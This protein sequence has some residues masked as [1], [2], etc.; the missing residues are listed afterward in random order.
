MA[1]YKIEDFH[2]NYRNELFGG[3]DIKGLNIYTEQ[4]EKVGTVSTALVDD[5]GRFRYLVMDTGFWIF[6]KKVLL[7]VGRFRSD[8]RSQRI[9]LK[10]LS[11]QQAEQL[12]EYDEHMTVDYDYEERVRGVYRTAPL[13]NGV[14]LERMPTETRTAAVSAP[15]PSE[16]VRNNIPPAQPVVNPPVSNTTTS[17]PGFDR[18]DRDA[19][20]DRTPYNRNTYRYEQEPSLYSMNEQDHQ[21]FR[22]YEEQLVANKDRRKVGE[23]SVGKRIETETTQVAVPV[24]QERVVIQHNP[25]ANRGVAVTPGATDF[26]SGEVMRVDL[27]EETVDITK[28][29][30]VRDEVVIRKEVRQDT[31]TTEETLRRE[32]LDINTAG[33]PLI[34]ERPLL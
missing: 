8:P 21:T 12:P 34:D 24:Q 14:P 9:Y 6:G 22:L 2:P 10:G 18:L 27:Y 7:P 3:E 1:L 5:D 19:D 17:T 11:R 31:V 23:V 25:T 30:V 16:R 33:R 20:R 15:Q 26:Q 4:D 29:P 13:E 28:Q 32:E